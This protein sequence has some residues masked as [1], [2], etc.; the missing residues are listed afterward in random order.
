MF[1][2]DGNKKYGDDKMRQ[3]WIIEYDQNFVMKSGWICLGITITCGMTYLICKYHKRTFY[4]VTFV[5]MYI[6]Q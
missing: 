3:D 4:N 1:L 2:L 6:Y 5:Y